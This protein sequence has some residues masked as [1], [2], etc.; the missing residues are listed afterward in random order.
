MSPH[1]MLH[2]AISSTPVTETAHLDSSSKMNGSQGKT[3]ISHQDFLLYVNQ[4]LN[5]HSQEL[6]SPSDAKTWSPTSIAAQNP[7]MKEVIDL[8]ILRCNS[9]TS[10]KLSPNRFEITRSGNRIAVLFLAR[11]AYRLGETV[12]VAVDFQ[13][14]DVRCH[15][16]HATLETSEIIDPAIALRSKA[17]V[18]RISRRI[19]AS[20]SSFTVSAKRILFSPNIPISSTPDFVTSGVS[21]EWRLRFEFVTDSPTRDEREAGTR[22]QDLLEEVS[23]DERGSVLAAVQAISCDTFDVSVPLKVYGATNGSNDKRRADDLLI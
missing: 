22:Y 2:G 1:I 15:S 19:H 18:Y 4:L 16:C 14:S 10:T 12:S 3:H 8:A 9:T 20:Q 13:K 5:K 23:R 7:P 11:P 6:L 17:S 21:L